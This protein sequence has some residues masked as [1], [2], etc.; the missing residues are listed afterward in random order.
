MNNLEA[1]KSAVSYPI[2]EMK[3]RK[4]LIDQSIDENGI[5]SG[6][7]QSFELATAAVYI[8]ILT[9]AN[10]SEGDYQ[11]SMTDKSN[12]FKLVGAIYSKYGLKNPLNTS[13]IKNK[14]NYW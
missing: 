8:L 11:L 14:S 3:L 13:T 1:L 4:A 7:S 10:V 6:L 2:D 12:M 9:A 5:Y